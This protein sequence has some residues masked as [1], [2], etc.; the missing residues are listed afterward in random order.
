MSL[1]LALSILL[2]SLSVVAADK[3]IT[4]G[5]LESTQ[6]QILG[7]ILGLYLE[8]NGFQVS[9]EVDLSSITLHRTMAEGMVDIAWEDPAIVWFIKF[10]KVEILPD[11][12]LYERVK[13][14]EREEGLLWLGRSNLE[15]QYVLVMEREAAGGLG[16]ETISDL[17]TYARENRGEIRMAMEDECFFRPDCYG[18]L[19]EA[20][21][22]S[23]PRADIT[24]TMSGVG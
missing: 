21:G 13:G 12:E 14:L 4:I 9:Y 15:K 19:K 17:A 24:T 1:I 11:E 8:D 3:S 7:N 23:L 2:L 16:V 18:S 10:L 20:Y 5:T 6:Q 22:L